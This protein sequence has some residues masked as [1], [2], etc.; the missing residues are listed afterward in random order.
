MERAYLPP[1]PYPVLPRRLPSPSRCSGM[2][3]LSRQRFQLTAAS[4]SLV[5]LPPRTGQGS[6]GSSCQK[7]SG[8]SEQAG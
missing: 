2:R 1:A 5:L 8:L 3:D 4:A 6:A 7:S